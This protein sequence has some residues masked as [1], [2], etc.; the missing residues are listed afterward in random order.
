MAKITKA[1]AINN[2]K[3]F[4]ESY[5]IHRDAVANAEAK[6]K[7]AIAQE[8]AAKNVLKD[9]AQQN[10]TTL[11]AEG[12]ATAKINGDVIVQRR[13]GP[14]TYNFSLATK[15][16]REYLMAT[17]PN[18]FSSVKTRFVDGD[19]SKAQAI[20]RKCATIAEPTYIVTLASNSKARHARF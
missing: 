10:D 14:T 15:S 19:D 8:E 4:E 2:A 11:F 5:R 7:D 13:N 9:Y 6:V 3:T 1:T 12:A 17:Y 18:A 16:E 20:L